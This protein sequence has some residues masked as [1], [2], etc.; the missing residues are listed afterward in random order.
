MLDPALLDILTRRHKAMALVSSRAE[1]LLATF[2]RQLLAE[3]GGLLAAELSTHL[4]S[5]IRGALRVS[6]PFSGD[7]T[8]E[9]YPSAAYAWSCAMHRLQM[10]FP[11]TE[12]QRV[13]LLS[14]RGA[15]GAITRVADHILEV[16]LRQLTSESLRTLIRAHLT[17]ACG[18][19]QS[20]VD[21]LLDAEALSDKDSDL[22]SGI[23]DGLHCDAQGWSAGQ[24]RAAGDGVSCQ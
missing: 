18:V 10:D 5:F 23:H 7:G 6:N 2:L 12:P 19:P 3:G 21:T 11:V 20:L 24:V 9:V 8:A 15:S 13:L 17:L 16:R 22:L 14:L 1:L 4:P